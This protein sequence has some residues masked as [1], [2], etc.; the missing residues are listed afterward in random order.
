M[1]VICDLKVEVMTTDLNT[2]LGN[3]LH[4]PWVPLTFLFRFCVAEH[5]RSIC[6]ILY[7]RWIKKTFW[8][9][10]IFQY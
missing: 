8:V 3:F 4:W 10:T 6:N 7:V 9:V 5:I 1:F 2:K